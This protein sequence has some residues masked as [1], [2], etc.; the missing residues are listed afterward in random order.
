M[1]FYNEII[2]FRDFVV[3]NFYTKI[4]GLYDEINEEIIFPPWLYFFNIFPYFIF[5][6]NSFGYNY[7]YNND[8][9]IYYSHYYNI[10]DIYPIMRNVNLFDSSKNNIDITSMIRKYHFSV[11]LKIIYINEKIIGEYILVKYFSKGTKEKKIYFSNL[12]MESFGF[13]LK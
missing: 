13:L 5:I 12:G 2:L 10:N 6:L 1:Y 3:K 7:I 8:N 9:I 11:P 4:M